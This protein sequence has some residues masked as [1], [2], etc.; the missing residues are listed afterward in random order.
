MSSRWPVGRGGIWASVGVGAL[1]LVTTAD[2][3]Q[4][5]QLPIGAA[6]ALGVMRALAL[7]LVWLR[8]QWALPVSLATSVLTAI[9]CVPVSLDEA[10]PWPVSGVFGHSLVLA[11][12]GARGATALTTSARG[13]TDLTSG[14]RGA[15]GA[16]LTGARGAVDLTGVRGATELTV[17]GGRGSTRW[18]SARWVSSRWGLAGWWV[19]TQLV[20]VVGMAL[21]PER[22]SWAGL[23]TMA[24]LSA[25]AVVVAYLVRSRAVARQQLVEQEEISAAE[26]GQRARL[27]ERARIARE[28][29]DV[30]AHHLSVVVVRADSAPHRLNGLADDARDEFAGIA[31]DARSSLT[32]MRRVLRLL[33]EDPG[34]ERASAELGPQPGLADLPELVAATQRAGADV[35]LELDTSLSERGSRRG[36][37]SGHGALRQ[38]AGEGGV[39]GQGAG[40]DGVL[41]QGT[42]ADGVLAQ[43]AGEGGV[44]GQGAGAD[45]AVGRG[46]G[47]GGVLGQSA[48]EDEVLGRGVGEGGVVGRGAGE[49]GA[50]ERGVVGRGVDPAVELTAYRVVQEAVSNAVRHAPGG[51]V[52]VS[53]RRVGG[54]LI[55]SVVNGPMAGGVGAA[56]ASGRGT[57][58]SGSG[59]GLVGMRE[60]VGLLDGRV[61]AAPTA[62]GGYQV[63]VALPLGEQSAEERTDGEG[64]G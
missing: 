6:F 18:A 13:A 21:A 22:G 8:P 4:H 60:R 55:V 49:G 25:V 44:V 15:A 26:R 10:W 30:V 32:E 19:V 58:A 27:Q 37:A 47:E 33:R 3:G 51:V 2:L 48:G 9:V 24:V 45:D 17:G 1:L 28:L 12:A 23:L 36:A 7:A 52:D 57:V 54:E 59:H 64:V 5:Y 42:G 31:E 40:A 11:F 62:D 53:V 14:A 41:G 29:H 38:G 56:V 34:S 63:E 20:G 43:G 16:D 50:G 61:H 46:A 39:L 35:R